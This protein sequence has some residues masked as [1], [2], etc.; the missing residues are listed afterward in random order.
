MVR[1]IGLTG[2]AGL[3]L[4]GV[5]FSLGAFS[6]SA[7]SEHGIGFS[8]GCDT[9]TKVGDPYVCSYTIRNNSDDLGD[10]LTFTSL[11]DTV[12]AFDGPKT[13]TNI[14][15]DGALVLQTAPGTGV[16]T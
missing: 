15:H 2:F 16:C 4:I 5:L 7:Q 3:C 1:R 8:K 14:V 6:A 13:S 9:P 10:D 12:F 11:V